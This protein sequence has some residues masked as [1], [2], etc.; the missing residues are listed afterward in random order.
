MSINWYPGHMH[1]ASKEMTEVLPQVNL[2]V[3][4][5]DARIPFSSSNPFIQSLCADKPRIKLL[6]KTD[7]ADTEITKIW[8][9]YFESQNYT[10]SI[11][12]DLKS[13]DPSAAIIDLINKLYPQREG[14][15]TLAMVTGI[16]N[17]GK[18]TLINNLAGKYIA[19]TGDEPAITKGQQ[20]I[21]LRNGIMLL[22]TPGVLWPKIE[23][24]NSGYRLGTT[25]AIKDT[26][27]SYEELAFFAIDFFLKHY[28]ERLKQRFNLQQ[29]PDTELELLEIIGL[30]RGCLRGG[31]QVDLERVSSLFINELRAG[32]LGPISFETPQVIEQEMQQ[33][34]VLREEK[35]ARDKL[36]QE[37]SAARRKKAKANRKK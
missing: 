28:P 27:I 30:Q 18:S 11:A 26:A 9:A 12:L 13:T 25:G 14:R 34:A 20:R 17:V 5:L 7:L 31:N 3:E 19:K 15:S 2:V 33:V 35:E 4:L 36:R 22:D 16:P 8:Q 37:K 6:N 29:L 21:N 24:P 1:R 10:K 23:N 32:I